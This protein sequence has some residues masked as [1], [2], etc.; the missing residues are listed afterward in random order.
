MTLFNHTLDFIQRAQRSLLGRNTV[1]MILGTLARSGMQVACFIIV[2]RCLGPREFG[3]FVGIVALIAVASPFSGM[4]AGN[5]LVKHVSRH[6]E[7]FPRHWGYA[8]VA[9]VSSAVILVSLVLLLSPY[10]VSSSV[11]TSAV[12]V[13]AL[14]DLLFIRVVETSA[15]AFQAHHRL[16]STAL[17]QTA[18][19]GTRLAAAVVLTSSI[20]NPLLIDWAWLYLASGVLSAGIAV[21]CV[22]RSFGSPRLDRW[23]TLAEVKEGAYFAVSLSAQ[24]VH[25][26]I[27]KTMLA[28][29]DSLEVAGTYGAAY[30]IIDAAFTPVK[31]LLAAA[32]G[33]FFQHGSSGIQATLRFAA[34]LMPLPTAYAV[35]SAVLIWLLAPAVPALLGPTYGSSVSTV[36]WLAALPLL[37][38]LHYFAADSLTGAGFQGFR[39]STQVLVALLNALLTLLL[40]PSYSWRGAAAASLLSDSLLVVGFWSLAWHLSQRRHSSR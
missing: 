14:S 39:S 34:R 22:G 13:L 16:G 9:T 28:R 27:D 10:L 4:G 3:A 40:I 1:W 30:R 8:L 29:M 20:R 36:R 33:Q 25:N 12:V 15:Q 11:S 18:L 6:P 24:A 21:W 32:Y 23:W 5:L 2:A 35:L 31:A 37:R 17:L 38:T 19:S 26:D 7:T